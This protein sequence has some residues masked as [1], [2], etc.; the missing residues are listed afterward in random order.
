VTASII[1]P[2][3]SNW[4]RDTLPLLDSIETYEPDLPVI[5]IDNASEPPYSKYEG[6]QQ[7]RLRRDS[8]YS[9]SRA[10][11][12]GMRAAGVVDWSLIVQNDMILTR[13]FSE[14]LE[15]L[16]PHFHYCGEVMP[17]KDTRPWEYGVGRPSVI[18]RALY[19]AIGDWDE[20][21]KP[22]YCEDVDYSWRATKAGFP[23]KFIDTGMKHSDYRDEER[24]RNFTRM[25]S[26]R[27][28][29]E[30]YLAEKHNTKA[31]NP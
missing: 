19:E 14:E 5:L 31:M 10:I 28:I 7:I 16:D 30:H 27:N 9:L 2:G 11:N 3:Y 23:L 4:T 13:S 8:N 1:I 29:N 26:Y 25:N 21:F 12:V 17:V 20:N 18:S 24:K 15:A 22:L 6:V